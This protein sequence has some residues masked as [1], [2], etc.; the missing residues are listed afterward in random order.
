MHFRVYLI[1]KPK[2]NRFSISCENYYR[3][4]F[5]CFLIPSRIVRWMVIREHINKVQQLIIKKKLWHAFVFVTNICEVK[6]GNK[7]FS[8]QA[9][10]NGNKTTVPPKE[11]NQEIYNPFKQEKDLGCKIAKKVMYPTKFKGSVL[12]CSTSQHSRRNDH[13]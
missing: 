5:E 1:I 12:Y 13:L 6:M 10:A 11:Q 3:Y 4:S 2:I 9:T 7:Q 8:Q